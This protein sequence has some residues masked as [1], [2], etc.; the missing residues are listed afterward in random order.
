MAQ[1]SVLL[2]VEEDPLPAGRPWPEAE[3]GTGLVLP[4]GT[5]PLPTQ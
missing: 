1:C 4:V 2:I 3:P 5:I